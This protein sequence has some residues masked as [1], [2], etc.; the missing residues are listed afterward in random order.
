MT[1]ATLSWRRDAPAL[2]TTINGSRNRA[3]D[4]TNEAVGRQATDSAGA[5]SCSLR[6]RRHKIRRGI[7]H[8]RRHAKSEQVQVTRRSKENGRPTATNCRHVKTR[9]RPYMS[10]IYLPEGASRARLREAEH[11]RKNRI[12]IVRELSWGRVTRREL[13]KMGLF[14]GAGLLAPV[15]GLSP[16]ATTAYADDGS[17]IPTGAPRSPMF[18]VRPFTQPML[19][20]DCL[21]RKPLS[22]LT[23]A[24]T[25]AS[26]QTPRALPP[27]LGGGSGPI[28]GRPPGSVWAHQQFAALPPQVGVE[29]TQCGA[30]FNNGYDPEVQPSLNSGID[31]AAGCEP[32]F[33][34]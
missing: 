14:T 21:H 4:R 5:S 29:V 8:E 23:P 7:G 9:R 34:R 28:E 31:P 25:A 1:P 17:N 10:R 16:F 13:L 12:E 22:E 32:Y 24:P 2:R 30:L 6:R 3:R 26:N 27:E 33:H 19:R 18:G 11:A 15:R 20:F